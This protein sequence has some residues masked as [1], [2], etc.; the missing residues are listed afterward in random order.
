MTTNPQYTQNSGNDPK[1]DGLRLDNTAKNSPA[2]P[3]VTAKNV[4]DPQ[5]QKFEWLD[6][7][8]LQIAYEAGK[9]ER[10]KTI[11]A[12]CFPDAKSAIIARF[13]ELEQQ[14]RIAVDEARIS[15]AKLARRQFVQAVDDS[16]FIVANGE[17]IAHLEKPTKHP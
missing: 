16:D 2:Q 5:D 1:Q 13:T 4:G 10:G 17:R 8:I 12:D 15:E 14:H 11:S 3:K 9:I 6:E 7:A